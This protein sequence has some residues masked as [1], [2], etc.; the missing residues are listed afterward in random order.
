MNFKSKN[1]KFFN[2]KKSQKHKFN[3]LNLKK[4]SKY[5][6]KNKSEF[7][8]Q[9]KFLTKNKTVDKSNLNLFKIIPNFNLIKKNYKIY[10][11]YSLIIFVMFKI[12]ITNYLISSIIVLL[13]LINLIFL[14][15]INLLKPFIWVNNLDLS[16]DL[17]YFGL[18]I[19]SLILIISIIIIFLSLGMTGDYFLFFQNNYLDKI[20]SVLYVVLY[21][22]TLL[23]L[24]ILSGFLGLRKKRRAKGVY[25]WNN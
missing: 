16:D 9:S 1:K 5:N 23:W 21:I 6:S 15:V 17:K 14:L 11:W 19:L 7:K 22:S 13:I 2:K 25:I 4:K 20:N 18:K 12:I 10:G 8:N 3:T 24:L